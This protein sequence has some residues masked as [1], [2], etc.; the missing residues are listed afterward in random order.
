M[1]DFM[2]DLRGRFEQLTRTTAASLSGTDIDWKRIDQV[3]A[4]LVRMRFRSG[5]KCVP[6]NELTLDKHGTVIDFASARDKRTFAQV[7]AQSSVSMRQQQRI[8]MKRWFAKNSQDT[9]AA[10]SKIIH[11][12]IYGTALSKSPVTDEDWQ[13]LSLRYRDD[14]PRHLHHEFGTHHS[15]PL[16]SQTSLDHSLPLAQD[17][18]PLNP[19]AHEPVIR[20][21]IESDASKLWKRTVERQTAEQPVGPLQ[22]ILSKSTENKTAHDSAEFL[23]IIAEE[24]AAAGTHAD[25]TQWGT[26]E[27]TSAAEPS[28]MTASA[29]LAQ[30]AETNEAAPAGHLTQSHA[31]TREAIALIGVRKTDASDAN[32]CNSAASTIDEDSAYIQHVKQVEECHSNVAAATREEIEAKRDALYAELIDDLTA[33]IESMKAAPETAPVATT[34]EAAMSPTFIDFINSQIAETN[35]LLDSQSIEILAS[36]FPEAED[37]TASEAINSLNFEPVAPD[38]TPLHLIVGTSEVI[39]FVAPSR[40]GIRSNQAN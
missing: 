29:P 21:L 8:A 30:I 27:F 25:M 40:N 6:I 23:Q 38:A 11:N 20:G 35:E 17:T 15:V 7:M 9:K 14:R 31:T 26:G 13:L 37:E 3:R 5:D 39:P 12:A 24:W 1:N 36:W 19:S 4:R 22:K 28:E 34:T 18:V 33:H 10:Q 2:A 32:G 16:I